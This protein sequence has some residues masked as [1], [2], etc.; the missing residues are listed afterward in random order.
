VR[1]KQATR[2]RSA[3]PLP[4]EVFLRTHGIERGILKAIS[5]IAS[6]RNTPWSDETAAVLIQAIQESGDGGDAYQAQYEPDVLAATQARDLPRLARAVFNFLMYL[7][8]VAASRA[9][10]A[11][12]KQDELERDGKAKIPFPTFAMR[13]HEV[14]GTL[15]DRARHVAKE[16]GGSYRDHLKRYERNRADVEAL[17]PR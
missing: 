4:L 11:R 7:V 17:A 3:R 6:S 14:T 12:A 13:W 5:D 1:R 9:V 8:A 15:T 2:R 10:L 16:E